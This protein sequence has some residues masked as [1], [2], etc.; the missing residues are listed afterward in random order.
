M[1][2]LEKYTGEKTYMF[3][4]GGLATKE[5]VLANYPAVLTFAH[6]VTTDENGE[7]MWAIENLSALRTLHGI[8]SSLSEAEAISAIQDIINTPAPEPE[9]S[10]EERSAAAL[11]FLAMS[12]IPDETEAV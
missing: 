5:T 8:D 4:A 11:E 3:P 1:K 9:V 10:P 7:I 12:S 6:V 2:V